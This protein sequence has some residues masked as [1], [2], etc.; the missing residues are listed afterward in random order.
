M[1]SRCKGGLV[2]SNIAHRAFWIG[3]SQHLSPAEANSHLPGVAE[4]AHNK[5]PLWKVQRYST[6]GVLRGQNLA[7]PPL[8]QHIRRVG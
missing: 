3:V 5:G 6:G 7:W 4:A 2:L 8:A 1:I